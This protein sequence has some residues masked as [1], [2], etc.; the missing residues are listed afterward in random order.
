MLSLDG[1]REVAILLVLLMDFVRHEGEGLFR[2]VAGSCWIGVDLFFVLSD[3]LL[4]GILQCRR[5]DRSACRRRQ[6]ALRRRTPEGPTGRF[7]CCT[8]SRCLDASGELSSTFLLRRR[9]RYSTHYPLAA[10]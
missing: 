2:Q 8:I 7:R 4:I 3:F 6:S 5:R 9:Y 1:L 10:N